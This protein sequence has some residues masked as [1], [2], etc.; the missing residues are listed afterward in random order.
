MIYEIKSPEMEGWARGGP[1]LQ[2]NQDRLAKDSAAQGV[3]Q[4]ARCPQLCGSKVGSRFQVPNVVPAPVKI[5]G[6]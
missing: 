4:G 1:G 2:F 5:I 3:M 6:P